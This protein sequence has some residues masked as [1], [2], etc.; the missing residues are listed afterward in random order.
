MQLWQVVRATCSTTKS[1]LSPLGGI[2]RW[3]TALTVSAISLKVS[4]TLASLRAAPLNPWACTGGA[5]G[6][7][8]LRMTP[9]GTAMA[10]AMPTP[11]LKASGSAPAA[12]GAAN[13]P[14]VQPAVNTPAQRQRSPGQ[15]QAAARLPIATASAAKA[16]VGPDAV[17]AAASAM[18]KTAV[19][20]SVPPMA[21][22]SPAPAASARP[23][24]KGPTAQ[25]CKQAVTA[26]S[27]RQTPCG[28]RAGKCA[29]AQPSPA[30]SRAVHPTVTVWEKFTRPPSRMICT[31]CAA[32]R[33]RQP[34][35][36]PALGRSSISRRTVAAAT[37]A[38]PSLMPSKAGWNAIPAASVPTAAARQ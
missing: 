3:Q 6:G 21:A 26:A 20:S 13:A 31:I 10:A 4:A 14:T 2:C 36:S 12:S 27:H 38:A 22:H 37:A 25:R 18:L 19:C 17:M 5:G 35:S 9:P 23:G 28:S 29:N 1:K 8:I 32:A 15:R 11:A 34:A 24:A 30:A 33:V 7:K 16:S